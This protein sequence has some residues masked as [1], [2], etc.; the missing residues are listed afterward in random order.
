MDLLHLVDRLEELVA[1]AQK[2]PIGNR[3][4]IEVTYEYIVLGSIEGTK[5]ED[6]V[7]EGDKFTRVERA[8]GVF[9]RRFAL[10]DSANPEGITASGKHGVLEIA[11]PKRPETT[12]RRIQINS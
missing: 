8:R 10:P 3:A 6:T 4:I 1:S 9:Y 7:G 12:A 11:I 2:M 5:F